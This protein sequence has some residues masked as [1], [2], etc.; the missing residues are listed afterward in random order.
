MTPTSGA[1]AGNRPGP[2]PRL[3]REEIVEA[4][5]EVGVDRLSVAAVADRLGVAPGTLYRY[6]DG[7]E[8]IAAAAVALVFAR[9]A[10]PDT[11]QGWRA[12]LEAEAALAFDLLLRYSGLIQDLG[13]DLSA[14]AG[15]RMRRIVAALHGAGFG[16]SAAVRVAD[17]VLDIVADGAHQ[18]RWV[19][20]PGGGPGDLSDPARA[21]LDS[22]DEQV[23]P[24]VEA[25]MN[26]PREHV[27]DKVALVLD[28]VEHRRATGRPGY[29]GIG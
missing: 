26:E 8:E 7:L 12:F 15:D 2:K 14:V 19:R 17:A 6:V 10:L 28:G 3:T 16:T 18:T 5:V 1:R 23:R 22:L 20:G 4:A 13:A 9:T 25:I 21:Y 27:L 24:G 29:A 11:T